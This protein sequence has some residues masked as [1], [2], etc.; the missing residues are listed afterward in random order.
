MP[1][2]IRTRGQSEPRPLEHVVPVAS[3]RATTIP[4]V[5]TVQRIETAAGETGEIV[6]LDNHVTLHMAGT[7][8]L[9]S[10]HGGKELASARMRP[11]LVHVRPALEG[12]RS[13]WDT[14]CE[15]SIVALA[16]RFV[17]RCAADL[18]KR[19]LSRIQL[20]S[21]IASSDPFLWCLGSKLDELAWL[22]DPPVVFMDQIA[23]SMAMHLVLTA[24]ATPVPII[25]R[26]LSRAALRRVDDYLTANLA[27]KVRLD[28]LAS[29]CGLS[30][31]H[32]ARQFKRETGTS[33][34]RF[35]RRR[36]MEEARRLLTDTTLSVESVATTVG[37]QD[38]RAFRRAFMAE[39]GVSPSQCRHGAGD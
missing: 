32:F 14:P 24:G 28:D 29:L 16:P 12:H 1:I 37:Y 15:L 11:G 5:G 20:R 30:A 39:Q 25:A 21:T 7:P 35:V 19:D 36:R 17:S 27:A 9:H 34:A 4:Q 10:W 2:F 33:P 8:A 26:S 23:Q 22:P 38:T 31:F 6:R 3:S 13:V 18:F